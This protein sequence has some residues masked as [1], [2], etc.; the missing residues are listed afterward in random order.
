MPYNPTPPIPTNP[1]RPSHPKELDFGPFR[2]RLAPFRLRLALFGSVLAPF[3][4]RFRARFRV[5]G[6]VGVGSGRGASVREKNITTL[7]RRVFSA[8]G[9]VAPDVGLAPSAAWRALPFHP[10][11][12]ST[13]REGLWLEGK[14]PPNAIGGRRRGGEGDRPKHARVARPTS[15]S[16][17]L[18]PLATVFKVPEGH[19]PRGTTLREALRRNLPLRGL[20]GNLPPQW[21]RRDRLMSR[22]K[23]C[24]ETIFVS[25]LSRN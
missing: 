3:R 17:R 1:P 13:G 6:G 18:G 19:H 8:S 15:G 21:A 14:G 10:V 12:P 11:R 4:V 20:C 2:L 23:N 25:H 16:S 5:L 7:S 24:R 22:G 9:R